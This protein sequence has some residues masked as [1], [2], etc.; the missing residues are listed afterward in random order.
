MRSINRSWVDE[1]KADIQT[2]GSTQ[3]TT[4]I[5]CIISRAQV[6]NKGDFIQNDMDKYD[7]YTL[8]GNHLRT[9]IQELLLE[10]GSEDT[11][12]HLRLVDIHVYAGMDNFNA[13][14]LANRHNQQ[15]VS[16]P[17]TFLDHVT[18]ARRLLYE[19]ASSDQDT[20]E[21]PTAQPHNYRKMLLRELSM[22]NTVTTFQY[23]LPV[24]KYYITVPHLP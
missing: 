15:Q 3:I 13:R 7:L 24:S 16:H 14:R 6:P 2:K 12:S 17:T 9:A 4:V 21:P 5:P 20:D 23:I 11:F 18:Q 8:G 19:M 10:E 22:D 1:I